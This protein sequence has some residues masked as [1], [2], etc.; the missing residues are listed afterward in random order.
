MYQKE[1]G[2]HLL[3]TTC[4]NKDSLHFIHGGVSLSFAKPKRTHYHY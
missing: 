1:L 2:V 3:K 4:S